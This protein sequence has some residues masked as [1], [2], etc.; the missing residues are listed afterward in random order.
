[1]GRRSDG[2]RSR[3]PRPIDNAPSAH[4]TRNATSTI[5]SS[6]SPPEN[7]NNCV[8]LCII[9]RNPHLHLLQT[10]FSESAQPDAFEQRLETNLDNAGENGH[11]VEFDAGEV[12]DAFGPQFAQSVADGRLAAQGHGRH[13]GVALRV[14]TV[15][16]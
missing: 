3:R 13:A 1:V 16:S 5:A 2:R 11:L 8:L 10:I 7:I 6:D 14:N 9:D 4:R 12:V 15:Q